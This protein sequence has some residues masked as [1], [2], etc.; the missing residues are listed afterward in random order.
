MKTFIFGGKETKSQ[1]LPRS[2]IFAASL[3]VVNSETPAIMQLPDT[4]IEYSDE[5]N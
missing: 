1:D 2:L 3:A 5:V 4:T